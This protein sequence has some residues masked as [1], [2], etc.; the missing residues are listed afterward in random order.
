MIWTIFNKYPENAEP[1]S[2]MIISRELAWVGH[3]FIHVLTL[4]HRL[5]QSCQ[6]LT[7]HILVALSSY[8]CNIS[9]KQKVI[10]Y[11]I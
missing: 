4:N 5:P 8:S 7:R 6:L 2:E 10:F 11:Y 3:V 9:V 1:Q